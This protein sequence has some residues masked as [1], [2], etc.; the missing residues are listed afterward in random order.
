MDEREKLN[1]R[2][3]GPYEILER[4][5]SAAYRLALPPE[6]SKIH[7]VFNVS[8]LKKD[9]SILNTSFHIRIYKIDKIYH[10]RRNWCK[11]WT[12]RRRCFDKDQ[13]LLLKYYGG[14]NT[15]IPTLKRLPRN[16]R[17]RFVKNIVCSNVRQFR[18]RNKL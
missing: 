16:G 5:G 6:L 17:I 11:Y 14:I 18:G 13:Y 8:L 10:L 12:T 1:P 4:V 2:Y 3:I 15:L 9:L 7:N